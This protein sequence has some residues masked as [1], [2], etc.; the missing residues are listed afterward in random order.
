MQLYLSDII[1]LMVASSRLIKRKKT[2]LLILIVVF[3]LV[4]GAGV[5]WYFHHLQQGGVDQV[6]TER[7]LTP[8]ERR[9]GAIVNAAVGGDIEAASD[10]F[11]EALAAAESDEAKAEL[12]RIRAAH[13]YRDGTVADE[14]KAQALADAEEAYR[15]H[16]GVAEAVLV[17]MVAEGMERHDL[18]ERFRPIVEQG[19]SQM[20]REYPAPEGVE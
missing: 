5:Y 13:L 20:P 8:E 18:V 15:L 3:L 11:S 17:L 16:D 12:Y 4:V 10:E 7:E 14:Q 6:D 19:R 2:W 1:M 9:H